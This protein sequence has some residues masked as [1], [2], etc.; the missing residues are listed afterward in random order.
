VREKIPLCYRVCERKRESV[1]VCLL[2]Q[3]EINIYVMREE[4]ILKKDKRDRSEE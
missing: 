4:E 2:K 3:R 1:W